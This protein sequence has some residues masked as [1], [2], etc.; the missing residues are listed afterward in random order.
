MKQLHIVIFSLL[1]LFRAHAI[2]HRVGQFVRDEVGLFNREPEMLGELSKQLDQFYEKYHIPFYV[3]VQSSTS[4]SSEISDQAND[5]RAQYLGDGVDGYLLLYEIDSGLFALSN[6]ATRIE[7]ISEKWKAPAVP[8]Y[9]ESDLR[10]QWGNLIQ[11]RIGLDAMMLS[12]DNFQPQKS[13]S[14]ISMIWMEV[15]GKYRDAQPQSRSFLPMVAGMILLLV[16]GIILTFALRIRQNKQITIEHNRFYFPT[17][18][19]KIRLG[20]QYSG[21]NVISKHYDGKVH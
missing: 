15:V 8:Q 2:E 9:V 14:Q 1:F 21:G 11:S 5:K 6:N 19:L 12:G 17:L 7:Q 20:A 4:S 13:C 16:S 10:T 3:V 18:S